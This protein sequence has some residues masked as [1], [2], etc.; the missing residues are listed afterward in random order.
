[1][2][3]ALTKAIPLYIVLIFLAIFAGVFAYGV[4]RFRQSVYNYNLLL[5]SAISGQENLQYGSWPALSNA[6]FFAKVRDKFIAEKTE[7]I[8]ADLSAMKLKYWKPEG[9]AAEVP[10]LTKGKEG[11]WWETPA[12]LY[13][14]E[15][16]ERNHFSSFGKVYQP[17]SMAFQG[18]FFLH[19]WPYYPNGTPVAS[20][21]S[22]GCIRLADEDAKKIFDLANVGTPVLVFSKDFGGDSFAY[23][24]GP[25]IAA[26]A[27]LAADLGSNFVF[28]EKDGR[29]SRS[30]ASITKLMTALVAAEYINLDKKI[31]VDERAI[32]ATSKPRLKAA[33][34]I[35]AYQLLFPLLMESSNEAANAFAYHVGKDRFVDLMNQK[36]RALGMTNTHFADASGA[37]PEN[38]STQEDLF[39]LA[40]YLLHNRSFILNL[41]AGRITAS[42]Y[43]NTEFSDIQNFNIFQDDPN[44]VGGKVG[45]TQAAGQTMMA[46]FN[47]K[48]RGEDRKVFVAVLGSSHRD[49]DMRRILAYVQ[50]NFK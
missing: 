1:M 36:A 19:G 7:F 25:V 49:E 8:E 13:R 30:I 11:S 14:I 46:I 23:S 26:P 44:F 24:T 38:V 17:W 37:S 9:V 3:Q 33:E 18:N 22:G 42:A 50:A 40:K 15:S 41:S 4:G 34:E 10:I 5:P 45:E 31:I 43:G 29:A 47:V 16:K 6:D 28:M 32:V 21:Y 2:K 27:Y 12:G 39:A 35:T 20:T 48:V